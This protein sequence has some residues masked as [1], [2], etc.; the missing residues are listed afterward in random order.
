MRSLF[1][2][3]LNNC[4]WTCGYACRPAAVQLP[5]N[6]IIDFRCNR[7]LAPSC[8]ISGDISSHVLCFN[9]NSWFLTQKSFA[10]R[11]LRI[12]VHVGS[13]NCWLIG[14]KTNDLFKFDNTISF[15]LFYVLLRTWRVCIFLN[16]MKRFRVHL[17]NK[18]N[19]AV[20][21]RGFVDATC[22]HICTHVAPA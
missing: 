16:D 3:L 9:E 18:L 17:S 13:F 4:A 11:T 1:F 14:A 8:Y 22:L 21:F 2:I 10:A 19:C 20:S 5:Y 7:R 15:I 6:L 12:S